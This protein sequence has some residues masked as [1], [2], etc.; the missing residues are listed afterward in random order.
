MNRQVV[1]NPNFRAERWEVS[2]AVDWIDVTPPERRWAVEGYIPHGTVTLITGDG[3]VGKSLLAQQL[4]TAAALGRPWLGLPTERARTLGIFC[5]DTRDELLR[6][7]QRIFENMQI[8]WGDMQRGELGLHSRV[9]HDNLLMA[10]GGFDE[11]GRSLDPNKGHPTDVYQAL[12]DACQQWDADLIVLDA[13]HDLFGGNENIR[14]QARQFVQLLHQ[15]ATDCDG[16]VVLLA[17]PSMAGINTGSGQ[18]GSTAWNN[19]VRSRLYLTRPPSEGDEPDDPDARLLKRM[20][21]NYG[22][23]GDSLALRYSGGVFVPDAP[24]T[25]MVASIG[26][27]RAETAFLDCLDAIERSGRTV[28][29]VKNAG[30]FAPRMMRTMPA[31]KR[32]KPIDLERAM[33]R[34]FEQGEIQVV[35]Y[36]RPSEPRHKIMRVGVSEAAQ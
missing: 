16:T 9:G 20:K 11:R 8:G 6:R 31:A 3:G 28:S 25:G 13:L 5:E 15:L 27:N 35:S 17:H 23:T 4:L 7:Q 34:L 1:A 22:P 2:D 19:A 12:H 26:R 29:A 21:A 36:G 24:D 33:N 14:P 32:L 18:S 30:N 10:F